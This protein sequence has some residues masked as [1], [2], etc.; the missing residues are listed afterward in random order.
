MIAAVSESK[1]QS[2]EVVSAFKAAAKSLQDEYDFVL[3]H[4]GLFGAFL[5]LVGLNAA[6][7]PTLAVVGLKGLETVWDSEQQVSNKA[8]I[9]WLR[10]WHAS[11]PSQEEE[12]PVFSESSAVTSLGLEELSPVLQGTE[13]RHVFVEF[14]AQWCVNCR[15][16]TPVWEQLAT[17]LSTPRE[18]H[19]LVV[20]AFDIDQEPLPVEAQLNVSVINEYA[21]IH[22]SSAGLRVA[23][24][25][26]LART[27]QHAGLLPRPSHPRSPHAVCHRTAQVL[28]ILYTR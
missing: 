18:G 21:I 10:D 7:L 19:Q 17:Q 1:E 28:V 4:G 3:F 9:Q 13:A 24:L 26:V 14:Y 11:R 23:Q 15:A 2:S 16:V 8:V 27:Q 5:P 12:T 22:R 20:G 25:R 6:Q